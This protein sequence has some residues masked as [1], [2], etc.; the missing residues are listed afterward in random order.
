M[1]E[2][3][4][5]HYGILGMK[6]GIRRFQNRDGTLT[7]AGKKR[8]AN[9]DSGDNENGKG[10][11][12]GKG[13]SGSSGS[14]KRSVSEMSDDELRSA[15]NRLEM[16]KRY[17]DLNPQ[18]VSVGKQLLQKSV[19]PAVADGGKRLLTDYLIKQGSKALGL[20][21]GV[22]EMSKLKKQVEKLN[23]EKQ[24]KD[25][26]RDRSQEEADAK[27]KVDADRAR[28]RVALITNNRHL[29]ELKK[30]AD[31]P[32]T[33]TLTAEQREKLKKKKT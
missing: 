16:E 25:L 6:W 24:L 22:D 3:K 11:K 15:I 18:K 20:E 7:A 1:T 8:A 28:N 5:Q 14:K 31:K 10:G 29:K 30:T 9:G 19:F 21:V 23:L 26:T 4:L 13:G 2:Q 17:R 12:G 32:K 27:L 33:Y